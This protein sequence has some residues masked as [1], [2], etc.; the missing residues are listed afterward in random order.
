MGVYTRKV[1]KGSKNK[2]SYTITLPLEIVEKYQLQNST[3]MI[4]DNGENIVICKTDQIAKTTTKKP[5]TS[6][7]SLL[8]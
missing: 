4:I 3:I 8:V 6:S 7:N 5:D 2:N 1:I